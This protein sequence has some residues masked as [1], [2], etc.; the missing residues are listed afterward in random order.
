MTSE[1]EL[2]SELVKWV[3]EKY[4]KIIIFSIPNAGVR[5]YKTANWFNSEGLTAGVP[6][7]F[8]A[9]PKGGYSGLFIEIKSN[10][11]HLTIKQSKIHSA[12]REAGYRC[13]VVSSLEYGINVIKEYINGE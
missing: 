8:L 2:Q 4:T 11:G 10:K 12:L 13:V 1:H 6:D 9:Y 7:L 3:R 5:S